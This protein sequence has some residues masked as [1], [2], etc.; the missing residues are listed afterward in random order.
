MLQIQDLRNEVA[1]K[2]QQDQ[3]LPLLATPPVAIEL[4]A[5]ADPVCHSSKLP[6]FHAHVTCVSSACIGRLQKPPAQWLLFSSNY[7]TS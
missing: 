1:S 5:K 2:L 4:P 3:A 7:H 6:S